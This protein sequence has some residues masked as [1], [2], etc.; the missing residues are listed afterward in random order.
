M[1]KST[2]GQ[3]D[4]RHVWKIMIITRRDC[5]SAEWIIILLSPWIFVSDVALQLDHGYEESRSTSSSMSMN[6]SDTLSFGRGFSE[7]DC[8]PGIQTN[9]ARKQFHNNHQKHLGFKYSYSPVT[10]SPSASSEETSFIKRPSNPNLLDVRA[11]KTPI[12][13]L[14]LLTHNAKHPPVSRLSYGNTS[15]VVTKNAIK[16]KL[17]RG[18][19]LNYL[20]DSILCHIFSYLTSRDL[21]M[22]SRVCRRFY[23]LSWEPSLWKSITLSGSTCN[24]DLGLKTIFR[25]LARQ[26][27]K[28]VVSGPLN[29]ENLSLGGCV[30]LTDRGLAIVA[31]RCPNI[32]SLEIQC[33]SKITNS[34][35]SDLVTKCPLLDHLD[36]TGTS[37]QS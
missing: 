11:T 22:T 5:G 30:R 27:G 13:D 29:V 35:I 25:I 26:S 8:Y 4:E 24:V 12:S 23:L 37:T 31:R 7:E 15:Q 9:Y 14:Y 10:P 16:D 18:F 21:I 2:D 6:E 19:A 1:L 28:S 34:G 3:T 20:P 17:A 36:V 33:C 32:R